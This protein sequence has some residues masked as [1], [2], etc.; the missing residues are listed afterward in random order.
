[1]PMSRAVRSSGKAGSTN[2]FWYVLFFIAVCCGW[3]NRFLASVLWPL[4]LT[5]WALQ[6]ASAWLKEQRSRWQPLA[7]VRS[8]AVPVTKEE[9]KSWLFR[10][11]FTKLPADEQPIEFYQAL[12]EEAVKKK[13]PEPGQ[14][15]PSAAAPPGRSSSPG[16]TRPQHIRS[17]GVA[18]TEALPPVSGARWLGAL[19]AGCVAGAVLSCVA[20]PAWCAELRLVHPSLDPSPWLRGLGAALGAW[21]V[22]SLPP[23]AGPLTDPLKLGCLASMA[24]ELGGGAVAYNLLLPTYFKLLPP[25]TFPFLLPLV[26][27]ALLPMAAGLLVPTAAAAYG[28]VRQRRAAAPLPP[29]TGGA[30]A[31]RA[32]KRAALLV[33][34][35]GV[36]GAAIAQALHAQGELARAAS[37]AGHVGRAEFGDAWRLILEAGRARGWD[38]PPPG[39]AFAQSKEDEVAKACRVLGVAPASREPTHAEVKKAYRKLALLYHPDKQPAEASEAEKAEAAARF[40]AA[41]DAHDT[42]IG[43]FGWKRGGGGGGGGGGGEDDGA[44]EPGEGD[45]EGE[46]EGEASPPRAPSD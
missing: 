13:Q 38:R 28:F 17:D 18:T 23:H 29:L 25:R 12:Y 11:T 5:V 31:V 16:R 19:L 15:T 27:S 10:N 26:Q 21:R 2:F 43:F 7:N 9:L 40:Q 41:Q 35:L 36:G 37:V 46:G 8:S 42:L 1:M 24:F 20:P 32:A 33:L 44:E 30:A 45:D 14:G 6:Y 34:G 3:I 39:G 4:L 22:L